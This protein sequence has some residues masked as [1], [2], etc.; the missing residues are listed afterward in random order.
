MNITNIQFLCKKYIDV[1]ATSISIWPLFQM[2]TLS[3][4]KQTSHNSENR[5]SS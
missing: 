5:Y 2:L 3:G 4:E 1:N